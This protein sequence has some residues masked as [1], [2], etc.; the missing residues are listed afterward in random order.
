MLKLK[1]LQLLIKSLIFSFWSAEN[2][3]MIKIN[4]ISYTKKRGV[5]L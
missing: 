3:G 5:I 4:Y 2:Y 1:N